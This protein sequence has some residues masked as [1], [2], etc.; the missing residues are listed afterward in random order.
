MVHELFQI[1]L[2]LLENSRTGLFKLANWS[3]GSS[4]RISILL[5]FVIV[6][7]EDVLDFRIER[8]DPVVKIAK[9][10]VGL[11]GRNTGFFTM[12]SLLGLGRSM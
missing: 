10:L 6:L 1:E 9:R 8:R 12:D 11:E 2:I 3:M 4:I 7:S 5:F